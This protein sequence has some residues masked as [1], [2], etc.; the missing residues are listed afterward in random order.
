MQAGSPFVMPLRKNIP[1]AK[2][3]SP[4]S[5]RGQYDEQDGAVPPSTAPLWAVASGAL[6][7]AATIRTIQKNVHPHEPFI[8]AIFIAV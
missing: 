8:A 6:V 5:S 7:I 1:K 4:T 3:Q 2:W